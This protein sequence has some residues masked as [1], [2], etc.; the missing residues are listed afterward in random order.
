MSAATDNGGSGRE[1]FEALDA[2]RGIAALGVAWGHFHGADIRGGAMHFAFYLFVD[3]FFILSGFVLAHRYL[4]E[5]LARRL[6]MPVFALHRF[7]RLYP[8]NVYALF[9]VLGISLIRGAV[10]APPELNGWAAIASGF[11]T[12]ADGNVFTFVLTLF[13]AQNV[14]LTPLGP[15][16]HGPSWSISV[17]FYAAL[18]LFFWIGLWRDNRNTTFVAPTLI[19]AL[20]CI[21][22]VVN[23]EGSLAVGGHDILPWVNYGLMRGLSEIAIGILAYRV[24]RAIGARIE[25][26][27]AVGTL[28]EIVLVALAGVLLFR[29]P[30]VAHEDIF[31]IPLFATLIFWLA[32]PRGFIAMLLGT[33]PLRW[34]GKLSYSIYINHYLVILILPMVALPRWPLLYFSI[35]VTLSWLTW[36]WIE[37]PA[38]RAINRK[39]SPYIN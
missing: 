7:A 39:L 19:L 28:I 9:G 37:V 22:A 3:L 6:K 35:V 12:Y 27:L 10:T 13:L 16:W 24:Y 34:I 32:V 17:E 25:A 30:F 38:R 4:D 21:L 5:W 20:V 8:M 29:K 31:A 36:R 18:F 14:G 26:S 15:S 2:L 33:R 11:E 23:G 1:R